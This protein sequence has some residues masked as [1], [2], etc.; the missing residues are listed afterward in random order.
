MSLFHWPSLYN[1]WM[2]YLHEFVQRYQD[3]RIERTRDM[4][5]KVL[6]QSPPAYKKI[7]FQMYANF[8][9]T[10]G[11]INHAIEIYDRMVQ[12]VKYGEKL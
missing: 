9:E 5:E 10:Y 1:I 4:F 2:I 6:S 7:F 8:E 11:L 3:Q 12:E